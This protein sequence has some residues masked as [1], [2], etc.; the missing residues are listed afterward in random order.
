MGSFLVHLRLPPMPSPCSRTTLYNSGKGA[1]FTRDGINELEASIM[2][3]RGFKKRCVAVAGLRRVKNPIVLARQMLEHGEQDLGGATAHRRDILTL[4]SEGDCAAPEPANQ[5][6]GG[7]MPPCDVEGPD[8]PSAQGHT[9]LFGRTAEALAEAYGLEPVGPEYFFTQRRWDDHI[10]GLER[11]R[12][13]KPGVSDETRGSTTATWDPDEYLPQGTCGAVA[14][15]GSGTICVATSTGG[16]TNKLTGRIGDTPTPRSRA[17]EWTEAGDPARPRDEAVAQGGSFQGA[18][19]LSEGLRGLLADCLPTP[20]A[21]SPMSRSQVA[22]S[23]TARAFAASG[24]GNGDSFLRLCAVRTVAAAARWGRVSSARALEYVTGPNGEL[25]RSAGER[26]GVTGEGEGGM[27]GIELAVSRDAE[28]RVLE[29]R[30][31]ILQDFNC[32]GMFRAWVGDD[33]VPSVAVFREEEP[34]EGSRTGRV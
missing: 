11:E 23:S 15:D 31:E 18:V 27:I 22:A 5:H 14:L 10:R 34:H 33:G 12:S 19:S 6:G 4:N 3:S 28:G 32:G 13:R 26:W 20:L 16:L 8:V 21:Y 25:Q 17:E 2:V 9:T 30:A 1:V 29:T 24:T 7:A